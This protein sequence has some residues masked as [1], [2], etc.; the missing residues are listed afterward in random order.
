MIDI[1][2]LKEGNLVF[3]GSGNNVWQGTVAGFNRIEKEIAVS[4]GADKYFFQSG[5]L[6]PIFVSD[7]LLTRMGFVKTS[8]DD[9]SVAYEK[10]DFTIW[11]PTT[12]NPPRYE[13][14]YR[15][16]TRH[17]METIW[18]HRIQNLHTE[19]TGVPLTA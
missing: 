1:R 5:D 7:D 11:F 17:I 4:N 12:N 9:G 3:V 18:L 14:K 16:D 19:M 15:D 8:N 10:E 2:E 13:V 6:N